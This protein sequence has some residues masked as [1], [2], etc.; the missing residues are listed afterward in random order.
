[1]VALGAT[2]TLDGTAGLAWTT[3]AIVVAA[4]MATAKHNNKR[5]GDRGRRAAATAAARFVDCWRRSVLGR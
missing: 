1:M 5:K 3:D 2:T 4:R